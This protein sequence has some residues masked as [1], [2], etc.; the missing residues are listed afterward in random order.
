VK[1]FLKHIFASLFSHPMP[2][3]I[4]F[5]LHLIQLNNLPIDI[6]PSLVHQTSNHMVHSSQFVHPGQFVQ[7]QQAV[8][9]PYDSYVSQEAMGMLSNVNVAPQIVLSQHHPNGMPHQGSINN[10]NDMLQAQLAQ[11]QLQTQSQQ[12]QSMTGF[13]GHNSPIRSFATLR[14]SMQQQQQATQQQINDQQAFQQQQS[15]RL[16]LTQSTGLGLQ[17]HRLGVNLPDTGSYHQDHAV[18]SVQTKIASFSQMQQQQDFDSEELEPRPI[19]PLASLQQFE[20]QV[21]QPQPPIPPPP[22]QHQQ[23][24]QPLYEGEARVSR[25]ASRRVPVRMPRRQGQSIERDGS[26][27]SLKMDG[28]FGGSGNSGSGHGKDQEQPP[29]AVMDNSG[30]SIMSLSIGDIVHKMSGD[31]FTKSTG[32]SD[33][34]DL[35]PLFDSSVRLTS[36]VE[37]KRRPVQRTN[38]SDGLGSTGSDHM[39]KSLDMSMATLGDRLSEF[40]ESAARMTESQADMSFAN[41]FEEEEDD[42]GGDDSHNL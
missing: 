28:V 32:S 40:G 26:E 21:P 7:T 4:P 9:S 19:G 37:K 15:S 12:H 17:G 39:G 35:A 20:Q 14:Q 22:Q 42:Y 29:R 5:T 1:P 33:P 25:V 23:Q 18:D 24:Q 3:P 11:M 6:D 10:G 13:V 8:T 16:S 2:I 41:V 27:R 34:D 30:V 36:T 31:D 38:S